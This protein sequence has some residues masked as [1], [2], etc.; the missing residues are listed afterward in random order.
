MVCAIRPPPLPNSLLTVNTRYFI[1]ASAYIEQ[2]PAERFGVQNLLLAPVVFR[3]VPA[4]RSAGNYNERGIAR[5]ACLVT[6]RK[7]GAKETTHAEARRGGLNNQ[8]PYTVGEHRCG[9]TPP[10]VHATLLIPE[11]KREVKAL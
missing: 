5:S 2:I 4:L 7:G 10:E 9:G 1:L 11:V 6:Y 3:S 8:L